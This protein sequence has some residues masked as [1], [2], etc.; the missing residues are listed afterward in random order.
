MPRGL[1]REVPQIVGIGANENARDYVEKIARRFEPYVPYVATLV[2][3][4]AKVFTEERVIARP[5]GL[6]RIHDENDVG[7]IDAGHC[8]VA[9]MA[10][11]YF[12]GSEPQLQLDD[13][14]FGNAHHSRLSQGVLFLHE[15]IYYTARGVFGHTDSR[16]TR[17][18]VGMLVNAAPIDSRSLT[19]LFQMLKLSDND[20]FPT[21]GDGWFAQNYLSV[22][23][24]Q[25]FTD[26]K[27]SVDEAVH[28]KARQDNTMLALRYNRWLEAAFLGAEGVILP[29]YEG[30]LLFP[31]P[32]NRHPDGTY[33][34]VENILHTTDESICK[35]SKTAGCTTTLRAILRDVHST[36]SRLHATAAQ[37]VLRPAQEKLFPAID[38]LPQF[39][40]AT[41]TQAKRLI[42]EM[43]QKSSL[44]IDHTIYRLYPGNDA[45]TALRSLSFNIP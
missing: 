1:K 6:N 17:K 18:L 15:S 3:R 23:A 26:T 20:Q 44:N 43:I 9:T 22:M 36:Y 40:D 31:E 14:L 32:A 42:T 10:A 35:Y 34:S 5:A 16:A 27:R 12:A 8:V 29:N 38:A 4:G 19:Q 30:G 7:Y 28:A 13:R 25:L 33:A 37:M 24:L 45:L 2:R 41:K 11:Q 39:T 21:M